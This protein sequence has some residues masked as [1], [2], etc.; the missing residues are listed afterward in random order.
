MDKVV[1]T[2]RLEIT[3]DGAEQLAGAWIRGLDQVNISGDALDVQARLTYV[4]ER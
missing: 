4:K 3:R 2:V 1:V